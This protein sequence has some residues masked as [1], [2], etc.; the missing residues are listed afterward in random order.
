MSPTTLPETRASRLCAVSFTLDGRL[1]RGANWVALVGSFNR[2]D[3]AVHHLT[4]T[5][6]AS[7]SITVTLV[8]GRYQYLFIVDG[9]SFNDPNDDGRECEWGGYYSVCVVR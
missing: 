4:P 8:P 6:D 2:W 9:H 3:T 7:W 1:A 5:P